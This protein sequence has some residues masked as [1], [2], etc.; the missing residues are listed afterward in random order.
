MV[1]CLFINDFPSWIW[2]FMGNL[3][4]F[5][6]IRLGKAISVGM[7]ILIGFKRVWRV[8]VVSLAKGVMS[9]QQK[10]Q[11]STGNKWQER[12]HRKSWV[13]T[14][15]AGAETLLLLSTSAFVFCSTA[16][17]SSFNRKREI[18]AFY[19]EYYL[20]ACCNGRGLPTPHQLCVVLPWGQSLK[21]WVV[22]SL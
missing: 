5:Q 22:I 12:D 4:L 9:S 1:F 11:H 21:L 14:L 15:L 10:P 13:H 2:P 20:L 7:L 17:L 18:I 8:A 19:N 6:G 3:G 16:F